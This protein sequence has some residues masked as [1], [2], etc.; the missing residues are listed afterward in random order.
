MRKA[1]LLYNPL[2][3]RRLKRRVADVEAAIAILRSAG[4]EVEAAATVSA[5]GTVEQTR[6]AIAKGCDTIFACGG[7][8]TIHDVLQALVG[9]HTALGIIPLGTANALAHD[10][11]IPR[12]AVP[13]ALLALSS[14]PRRIA[15]GL[16]RFQDFSGQPSSRYFTVTAGVGVDAHLFYQLNAL[17]K[18]RWGMLAYYMKA[19]R[20]W[21]THDMKMF[22]AGMHVSAEAESCA[23]QAVDGM[24]KDIRPE[25]VSQLL[26]VR[27]SQFGGILRE[28]APGAS[29]KRND[30]RLVLFK[31]QNR[32]FYLAYILRGLFG[33]RWTVPAIELIS[34]DRVA[35]TALSSMEKAGRI[36]VEADGELL[37]TLPV[38][39]SIV[40]NAFTLLVPRT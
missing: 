3:G 8:G 29:L 30:L 21:L 4:I 14:E 2:S 27:I 24:N 26:A 12:S 7:D 1:A 34:A 13:A 22:E 6:Q 25:Q 15:V 17:I 40:P 37:G 38:E 11:R 35:C 20:L 9:T 33:Q 39:I 16:V 10:L 36:F 32:L 31:T 5:A 28:L 18:G 23:N 19:T